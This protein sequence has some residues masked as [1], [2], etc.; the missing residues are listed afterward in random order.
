MPY[1]RFFVYLVNGMVFCAPAFGQVGS[2][3]SEQIDNIIV[4][5]SRSPIELVNA[6]SAATVITRDQIE[7]RQARY[8]TDLLR[9]V[10]GFAVSQ[11]GTTGSQTQVRVRGAEANHVLVLIDGVRANDPASGDEFRWEGPQSSLWGSDAVSAVV[12]VITQSGG[13]RSGMSG[14]AEGGSHNTVNGGING[15]IGGDR[16]SLGFGVEHLDTDGTNISRSG[17]EKDDSDMTTASLSSWGC[18]P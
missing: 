10:P 3:P 6:G 16:W 17:A 2:D 13:H 8:V 15:G 11:V 1:R 12:H 18:V 4:T 5:A 9:S 7:L 14:Y